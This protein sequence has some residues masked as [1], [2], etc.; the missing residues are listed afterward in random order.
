MRH[1]LFIVTAPRGKRVFRMIQC[2]AQTRD[3]AVPKDG[4]NP[5][6]DLFI[7]IVMLRSNIAHH[8]LGSG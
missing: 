4:P 2:L 8:R 5:R 1:G 6:N 7:R 3:V